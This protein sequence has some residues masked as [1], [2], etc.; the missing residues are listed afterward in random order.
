[1]SDKDG[2]PA[3]PMVMPSERFTRVSDGASL[4][5]YFAAH[6]SAPTTLIAS[7]EAMS[8]DA[9]EAAMVLASWRY[10]CAD[11]MLKERSK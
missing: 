4:R 5:D 9:E 6:A 10:L 11:A 2:G 3:F 7:I 8:K 1:M